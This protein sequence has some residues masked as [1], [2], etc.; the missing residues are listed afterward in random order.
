MQTHTSPQE[1]PVCRLWRGEDR[2]AGL[3]ERA[4][5][6]GVAGG[7]RRGFTLTEMLIVMLVIAVLVALLFPALAKARRLSNITYCKNNL[8]N[9]GKA[10]RTY[11]AEFNFNDY[12]PRITYLARDLHQDKVFLCRED[13]SEGKQGGKPDGKDQFGKKIPQFTETDELGPPQQSDTKPCSY[14]Y[15]FSGEECD[16]YPSGGKWFIGYVSYSFKKYGTLPDHFRARATSMSEVTW[17]DVKKKQMEYGDQYLN[18]KLNL[19][20]YAQ[21]RFPVIRCWWHTENMNDQQEKE[22]L[23]LS[24]EHRVFKS[25]P[26]WEET[27]GP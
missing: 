23:N 19:A 20:S 7:G 25:G 3:P 17:Q 18:G 26:Q 1:T 6:R 13:P 2:P 12:P 15:E 27:S 9:I 11:Q 8:Q 22:V 5:H 10:L 21:S 14:F 24:A 4:A 16:K